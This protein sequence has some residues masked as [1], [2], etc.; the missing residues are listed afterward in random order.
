MKGLQKQYEISLIRLAPNVALYILCLFTKYWEGKKSVIKRQTS[1]ATG[2]YE[3][4]KVTMS[5]YEPDYKWL[6]VTTSDYK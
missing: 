5:D 6:Q 3:L 4:L 1:Q 2:G